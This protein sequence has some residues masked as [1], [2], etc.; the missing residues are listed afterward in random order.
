MLSRSVLSSL[1]GACCLT[2]CFAG[3]GACADQRT[4]AVVIDS[5]WSSDYARIGC[6]QT[7]S[8]FDE[9]IAS[10]AGPLPV[11]RARTGRRPQA[12]MR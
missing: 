8:F 9:E 2:F 11:I 10:R 6:E 5:W 12:S 1:I 3:V 7:K 4:A